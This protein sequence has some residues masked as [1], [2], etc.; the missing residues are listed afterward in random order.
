MNTPETAAVGNPL[1]LRDL[2]IEALPEETSDHGQHP[3][4]RRVYLPGS[5]AKA[6]GPNTMVVSGMR[7]AGKS[8][9]WA[10][11][12]DGRIR[13]MVDRLN[14]RAGVSEKTSVQV[15]FGEQPRPG[16]YPDR[17]TLR[18]MLEGGSDPRLIW[19]TVVVHKVAPIGHAIRERSLWTERLGW[20]QENTESVGNLLDER[21]REF[22]RDETWFLV[23]FDALDRSA[24]QWADIN[25]LVRG[26]LQVALDLRPYRRLRLKCFLREDQ[27]DERRVADFPDASKVLTS[28]VDLTWPRPDLYGLLCQYAVNAEHPG[29]QDFRERA[30]SHR[31]TLS[32]VPAGD[33]EVW[34]PS[35]DGD[36]EAPQRELFHS[37]TGEW[38][39]TDHR[40]GFPYSWLPGHLAD[41]YGRTSP[42]TFLAALRKAAQDTRQRHPR[43]EFVL[44]HESIKRGVQEASKIRV[45]EVKEDH[46]WVDL[47][48]EPLARLVVPCGF[49]QVVDRWEAEKT[50]KK[51]DEKIQAREERF[52]SAHWGEGPEGLRKDLEALA[53]FMRMN[54]GRVNIPDV[55]RV[56]YGLGRRGGV[57][58]IRRTEA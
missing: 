52:R 53:V 8:F 5:H 4:P 16:E 43:H 20:V 40:R 25:R 50:L 36:P 49:D 35:P 17:D 27:I 51:L 14:P 30:H 48:M 3:D 23:L 57:K 1:A 29:A 37:L 15:G 58:P 9:W 32:P 38:M 46:P 47:L 18:R 28:K 11:L 54:D 39:G 56:G 6:I 34:H 13:S 44:H 7:G 2:L 24:D 33:V 45:R 21:D 12:Q 42:R 55:F 41:A 26:L 22:E 10:A 31:V 19:R